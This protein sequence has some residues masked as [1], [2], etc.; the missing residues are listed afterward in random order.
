MNPKVNQKTCNLAVCSIASYAN[1][2]DTSSPVKL[3]VYEKNPPVTGVVPS[4]KAS[5][6]NPLH[7]FTSS[8]TNISIS[9]ADI[10]YIYELYERSVDCR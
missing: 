1:K 6:G 8:W 5:D 10:S 4:Q 7:V 9:Y 3:N 2:K